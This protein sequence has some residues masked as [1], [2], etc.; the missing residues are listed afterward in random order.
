MVRRFLAGACAALALTLGACGA[1]P[2]VITPTAAVTAAPAAATAGAAA[3]PATPAAAAAATAN[4]PAIEQAVRQKLKDA[5]MTGP[6][7]I[8]VEA[9]VGD[10][11][12]V[13]AIPADLAQVDPAWMFLKK[14]GDQ[15]VVLAGPGTAFPPEDLT[16]VGLPATLAPGDENSAAA[17]EQ[18]V[19]ERLNAD[20]ATTTYTVTIQ[21]GVGD[22]VRARAIPTDPAVIDPAWLFLQRSGSAWRVVA[23]PGSAFAPEDLA[24][25]GVPAALAPGAEP[26]TP[27]CDTLREP[28][29]ALL[30]VD[31]A[32]SAADFNDIIGG[33]N[34]SGCQLSAAGTGANFSSVADVARQI[35]AL[36]AE[37]GWQADPQYVADGPTGALQGY[38]NAGELAQVSVDWEPAAEADCPSDQPV[39][40]CKLTP[41]QQLYTITLNAAPATQR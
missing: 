16:S 12:R 38:R 3:A 29:A 40:D 13:Q 27:T 34:L 35:G 26:G 1:P 19:R 15:W 23:G 30:K 24:A 37:R 7:T 21:A 10:A 33:G 31:V 20:G 41:A 32:Q 9:V 25:A 36:L 11:A 14:Q 5:G 28:L 22:F 2:A 4:D 8:I 17:I 18:A 6:Y 39:T